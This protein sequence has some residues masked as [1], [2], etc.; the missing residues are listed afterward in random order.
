M[1]SGC[2]FFGGKLVF[3]LWLSQGEAAA[4]LVVKRCLFHRD[5]HV[6]VHRAGLA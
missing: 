2:E 6:D 5:P 3:Y 1:D 4:V